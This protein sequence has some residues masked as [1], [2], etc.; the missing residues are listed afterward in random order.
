MMR[1]YSSASQVLFMVKKEMCS[2]EF[3]G[4]LANVH[5]FVYRS[6][7]FLCFLK[8]FLVVSLRRR[9][10]DR[11]RSIGTAFPSIVLHE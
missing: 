9:I 5:G 1:E 10:D 11:E 3:R 7:L 6:Y 2:E 8:L 4:I